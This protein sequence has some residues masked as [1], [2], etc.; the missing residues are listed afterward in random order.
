MRQTMQDITSIGKKRVI[1]GDFKIDI[2]KL[3]SNLHIPFYIWICYEVM[4]PFN[5]LW[6]SELESH[7]LPVHC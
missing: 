3:K 7:L 2:L 4:S 1:L 5:L 6:I